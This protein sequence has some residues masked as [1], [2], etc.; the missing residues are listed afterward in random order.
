MKKNNLKKICI[1]G[2]GGHATSCV[3]LIESTKKFEIVGIISKKKDQKNVNKFL[4]KYQIIDNNNDYKKIFKVCKNIVIGISLYKDLSVRNKMFE[5]LKKIGFN[6]PVIC[7]PKSYI[8]LGVKIDEG[9]QI[10]HGVTIN[11]NVNI[12]K[13]CIIN[14]H[15]LIEHDVLINQNSQIS[16][17]A[18]I[19]GGCIIKENS[20]IGSGSIIR[21]NIIIKKKSFI[22]MGTIIK[23]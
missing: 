18:I 1:I 8:S 15:A 3:D 14:S 17:G 19:N 23:K 22:K 11:K 13:N 10:F 6:L 9:T 21:E 5:D 4:N 2:S 12:G 7:S 20:F 16:T